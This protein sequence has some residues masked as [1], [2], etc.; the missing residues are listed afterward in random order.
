MKGMYQRKYCRSE[1]LLDNY[2]DKDLRNFLFPLNIAQWVLC[3]QKYSI[4]YNFITS[5]DRYAKFFSF[6]VTDMNLIYG[7]RLQKL[8]NHIID[9][10]VS[11][12]KRFHHSFACNGLASELIN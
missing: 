11:Q 5:N 6:F 2:I 10:W 12:M 7:I 3:S 1:F 9:T 4:R 8:I